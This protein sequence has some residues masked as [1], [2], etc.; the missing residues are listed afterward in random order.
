MELF[1]L[2]SLC[3]FAGLWILALL[4]RARSRRCPHCVTRIHRDAT[5]CPHCGGEVEPAP[6]TG[7]DAEIQARRAA[8]DAA[9]AAGAPP[10]PPAD[11]RRGGRQ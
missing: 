5:R 7:V 9:R 11:Q 2:V 4:D 3:L 8:D 6:F 10:L 1:A